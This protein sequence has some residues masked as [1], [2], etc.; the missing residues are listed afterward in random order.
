MAKQAALKMKPD[1]ARRAAEQGVTLVTKDKTKLEPR[2][3]AGVIDGLAEDA[4]ALSDQ[5]SSTVAARVQK[6]A[7]TATQ[8][9]TAGKLVDRV[10]AVRS[11]LQKTGADKVVQKKAG[12]GR[13]MSS[14]S[15]KSALAGADMVIE[16]YTKHPDELRA[17]GVLPK[18]VD[19]I[20]GLANALRAAD[21]AQE[22]QKVAAKL[23]TAERG[24]VQ[25]RVEAALM[26]V[27]AAAE[28]EFVESDPERVRQYQALIPAKPKKKPPKTA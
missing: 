4:G 27:I 1:E 14:R 7:S 25:R 2:V 6:L 9:V 20:I 15:V 21:A 11:A 26:R 22:G 16:T 28:L 24:N 5:V 13:T 3:G 12:V 8:N 19:T 10:M 23:S 18:D 17:A